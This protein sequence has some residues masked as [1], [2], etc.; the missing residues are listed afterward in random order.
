MGMILEG[1]V[2][3]GGLCAAWTFVMGFTGWYKDPRLL[4]VFFVVVM[5][6]IGVL[7]WALRRT[8]ATRGYAQ[9]VAAGMLMSFIAGCILFVSSLVFTTVVFPEYF[10]EIR[11]MQVQVLRAAG[12]SDAEIAA[13]M[14][15]IAVGQTPFRQ[16]FRGLIGTAGTGLVASMVIA[17]FFRARPT[18]A[19]PPA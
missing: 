15:A 2:L 16:A 14:Q 19:A 11:A 18:P 7:L 17:I 12:R 1:G 5:I 4:Y 3:I 8:A 6:Q 13:E 9:Q 10:D